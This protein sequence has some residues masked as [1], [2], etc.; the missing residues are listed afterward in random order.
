MDSSKKIFIK[1]PWWRSVRFLILLGVLL[2][3]GIVSV[4]SIFSKR[5]EIESGHTLP[6]SNKILTEQERADILKQ[7]SASTTLKESER[8]RI[9]KNNAATTQLSDVE[10]EKVI[11]QLSN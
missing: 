5:G 10:R 1:Q 6:I 4:A 8:A 9:Q 11:S 2:V 3:T 7:I